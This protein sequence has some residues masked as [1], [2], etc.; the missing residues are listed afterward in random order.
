MAKIR[1]EQVQQLLWN[2]SAL[3]T[4]AAEASQN[5]LSFYVPTNPNARV[6]TSNLMNVN[7]IANICCEL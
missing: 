4:A 1:A 7:I 5:E 6:G 3:L 2:V